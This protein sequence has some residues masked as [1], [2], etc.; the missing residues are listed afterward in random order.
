[1]STGAIEG[2]L[3]INGRGLVS[4]SEQNL[5]DCTFSYKNK[6]CNRGVMDYAFNYIHDY[7]IESEQDYPYEG[8]D[9]TCK[10]NESLSVTKIS[11]YRHIPEGDELALQKA[12]DQIGPISAG[13]HATNVFKYYTGG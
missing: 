1:M 7:G 12:V 8:S 10:F 6:G 11:G 9:D 4:L 3:A 13:I 5:I 2:Q